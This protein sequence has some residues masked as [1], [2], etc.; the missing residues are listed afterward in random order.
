MIEIITNTNSE[1]KTSGRSKFASQADGPGTFL[2]NGKTTKATF[3]NYTKNGRS[4]I[5]VYNFDNKS[6]SF[7]VYKDNTFLGI[8]DNVKFFSRYGKAVEGDY[9]QVEDDNIVCEI[10]GPNFPR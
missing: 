5:A 7:N 1:N 6:S 2:L 10:N 4:F 9:T 8:I 3:K